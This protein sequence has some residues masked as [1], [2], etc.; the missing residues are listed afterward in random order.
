MEATYGVT[1]NY[2]PLN[3]GISPQIAYGTML[4]TFFLGAVFLFYGSARQLFGGVK[5]D[6]TVS[7]KADKSQYVRWI[8]VAVLCLGIVTAVFLTVRRNPAGT[9]CRKPQADVQSHSLQEQ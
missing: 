5:V 2:P 1:D 3:F 6:A 4:V 8:V 7:V 9:D